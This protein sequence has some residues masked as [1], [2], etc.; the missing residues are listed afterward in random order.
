MT[1]AIFDLDHTLLDGDSDQLWGPYFAAKAGLDQDAHVRQA[2]QFYADYVKGKLDIEAFMA[3]ALE[4]LSQFDM[5]RLLEWRE[6]YVESVIRPIMLQSAVDLIETHRAKGDTLMI[7]TATNRFITAPIA[8]LFQVDHLLATQPEIENGQ[9]TGRYL[10]TPTFREGK[11]TVLHEWLAQNEQTLSGSY[12]YSDSANDIPLLE[13]VD[14]PVA[15][16]PDDRLKR[17]AEEKK[18]PIL[19]LK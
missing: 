9:F 11:V 6:E 12:F 1:L 15:T 10:G 16:N 14:N 18:W 19:L 3:F 5:T 8:E 7:I 2:Q 17:H 4:P 13:V